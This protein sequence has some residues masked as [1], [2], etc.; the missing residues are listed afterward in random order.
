MRRKPFIFICA[1]GPSSGAD[2]VAAAAVESNRG[3]E[4][5]AAPEPQSH[6]IRGSLHTGR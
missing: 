3:E 2:A 1:A 5:P 4:R 6:N